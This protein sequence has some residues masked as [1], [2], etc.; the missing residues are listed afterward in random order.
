MQRRTLTPDEADAVATLTEAIWALVGGDEDAH[1]AETHRNQIVCALAASHAGAKLHEAPQLLRCA[2]V[3]QR[4]SPKL[5]TYRTIHGVPGLQTDRTYTESDFVRSLNETTAIV[6][7][8]NREDLSSEEEA[9]LRRLLD[10]L[11]NLRRQS[12]WLPKG[13][14]S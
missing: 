1:E 2:A 7:R 14:S 10:V 3:T 9:V 4:T 12:R 8:L 5:M 13:R 6:Q 11:I